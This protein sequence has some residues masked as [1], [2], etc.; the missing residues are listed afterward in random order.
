[1]DP[2]TI[3]GLSVPILKNTSTNVDNDLVLEKFCAYPQSANSSL[4]APVNPI[5]QNIPGGILYP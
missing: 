3:H 4:K 1:M 5:C 2:Y